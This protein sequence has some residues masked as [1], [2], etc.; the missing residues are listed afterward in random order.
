MSSNL[1]NLTQPGKQ[2]PVKISQLEAP[3]DAVVME[4]L[5]NQNVTITN[6][7]AYVDGQ[8]LCFSNV[9]TAVKN[10]IDGVTPI[11]PVCGECGKFSDC[12]QVRIMYYN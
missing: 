12:L 10:A 7:T 2:V 11:E 6:N 9:S 4:Y 8:S 1:F 3:N 5:T